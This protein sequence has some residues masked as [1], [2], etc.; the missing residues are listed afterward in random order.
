MTSHKYGASQHGPNLITLFTGNCQVET[1]FSSDII[2]ERNETYYC[3]C[4]RSKHDKQ[5][6]T[7]LSFSY[8]SPF[9]PIP[10]P[11]SL[12][13]YPLPLS[14]PATQ[15]RNCRILIKRKGVQLFHINYSAPCLPQKT[16]KQT[17]QN[18]MYLTIVFDFSRDDRW[19]Q[20]LCKFFWVEEAG[21]EGVSKVLYGLFENGFNACHT[22]YC[23]EEC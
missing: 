14:T 18:K 8:P 9:S 4:S 11:F 12:S 5:T 2:I 6:T 20:W 13:P 1:L 16:N 21:G 15:A 3:S 19:K 17:K 23:F 10:L 22:G 7:S